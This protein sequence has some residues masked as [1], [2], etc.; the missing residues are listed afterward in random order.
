MFFLIS[1]GAIGYHES[2]LN[3]DE[4]SKA[5]HEQLKS[6][7]PELK[8]VDSNVSEQEVIESLQAVQDIDQLAG[9]MIGEHYEILSLLGQ[10]GLGAVYRAHHKLLNKVVAIKFLLPGKTMDANATMRFQR[11]AQA[12]VKLAH[13]NIAGVQEFGIHDGMPYMVMELVDG[14]SLEEIIKIEGALPPTRTLKITSQVLTAL[15]YAHRNGIVHRDIKPANIIVSTSEGTD[16]VKIIDFGI[17]KLLEEDQQVDLTKTGEVFGTPFYMSPEQCRGARVDYRTDIYAAGCV[18]YEMM[19]GFPPFQGDTAIEVVLK[20]V[21]EPPAILQAKPAFAGFEKVVDRAM[22]KDPNSRYGTAT[23]MLS[24]IALIEQGKKPKRTF[25]V[26]PG[27]LRKSVN[28]SVLALLCLLLSGLLFVALTGQEKTIRSLTA[29]IKKHPNHYANYVSRAILYGEQERNYNAAIADLNTAQRLKPED[30]II[31]ERRAQ[32]EIAGNQFDAALADLDK[33]LTLE[34][35]NVYAHIFRANANLGLN[36]YADA[37]SDVQKA[38]S[39]D[40]K[41]TTG[42]LAA[43]RV[44]ASKAFYRLEDYQ[45]ALDQADAAASLAPEAEVVGNKR[46]SSNRTVLFKVGEEAQLARARTLE[47]LRRFDEAAAA[48]DQAII[49]NPK[50]ISA[51]ALKA[52]CFDSLSRYDDALSAIEDAFQCPS[53]TGW[54]KQLAKLKENVLEHQRAEQQ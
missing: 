36:N 30:A 38:A 34:P 20:H 3:R 46:A 19:S 39:L 43:A 48:A 32:F 47:K 42:Q 15:A 40:P 2:N 25:Y 54:S 41:N 8:E 37:I 13:P 23:E 52:R 10:G 21:N 31:F 17:A 1:T 7:A 44:V 50:S 51:H 16:K 28:A 22:A 27:T 5:M 9:T 4:S 45:N 12:A 29:E 11:E 35:K 26:R 18:A 49:Y 53:T 24:E 14:R 6:E 33:A